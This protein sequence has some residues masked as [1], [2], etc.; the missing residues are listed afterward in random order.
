MSATV[1]SLRPR[2]RPH[3]SGKRGRP[4]HVPTDDLRTAVRVLRSV[5][6]AC[7]LI[8][9]L[10]RIGKLNLRRYYRDE[11]EW[12]HEEIK[13]AIGSIIVH[14]ALDGDVR[15]ACW[16]LERHGGPEWKKTEQR[17][18]GGLPGA[19]PIEIAGRARVVILP[20]DSLTGLR[21]PTVLPAEPLNAEP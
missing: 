13:A 8:A 7:D 3:G 11:L 14:K 21:M 20:S 9:R 16:W 6:V 12:G 18:Y 4:R 5:G 19:A 1:V 17:L 10:L 15:A 2:E